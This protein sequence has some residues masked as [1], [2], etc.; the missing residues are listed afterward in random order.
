MSEHDDDTRPSG[1]RLE[2]LPSLQ[3]FGQRLVATEGIPVRGARRMI[4]VTTLLA[5]LAAAATFTGAAAVALTAA[6]GSPIPS[7][8]RGDNT[9]VWPD[10]GSTRLSDL[11]AADPHGGSPWTV[12][13]GR[14][15]DGLVCVGV[16]QAVAGELGIRGLDGIF[17]PSSAVGSDQCG[18]APREG[19]PLVA[20]R[21]FAG[22][23]PA[24]PRGATTVVYGTGGAALERAEI[25]TGDGRTRQ[26][27]VG[28]A[29]SF[30]VAVAGWPEGVAPNVWLRWRNGREQTVRLGAADLVPDPD[31]RFGWTA[32]SWRGEGVISGRT[33]EGDPLSVLV[34][35]S[36]VQP[37][38]QER[39]RF[40]VCTSG[41]RGVARVQRIGGARY[42]G[43]P[44]Q[45][46][47]VPTHDA[48]DRTRITVKGR[49][50]PAVAGEANGPVVRQSGRRKTP[51]GWVAYRQWSFGRSTRVVLAVVPA[52]VRLADVA[53]T[54]ERGGRVSRLAVRRATGGR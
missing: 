19:S 17:R 51:R 16:G 34:G 23:D 27:A 54:I 43:G 38:R 36:T 28:T 50:V 3:A 42:G 12:R 49:A 20:V 18:P 8:A 30:V 31:G 45:V 5:A 47:V 4:T 15:G 7:F 1:A 39:Q 48:G 21:G 46:V 10:P 11:R 33:A 53:V 25:T 35:C 13:V 32:T 41:G 37:G 9:G 14:S 6:T 52:S 24:R 44:R 2:E 29:G 22:P 40:S 26:L